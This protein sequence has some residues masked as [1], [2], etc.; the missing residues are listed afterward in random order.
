MN[1]VLYDFFTADHRRIE[2]LLEKATQQPDEIDRE[3]YHQFRIGL[4]KHIKMEE[5]ILFPAA[6]K[7]NGGIDLPLQ[8]RLKKDHGALTALL[9]VS[10]NAGI[11]KILRHILELH[12]EL[13]E[14]EGGMYEACAALTQAETATL[15]SALQH[16]KEVPVHP[17]N[18]DAIA[19]QS[20]K[21]ALQRAGYDFEQLLKE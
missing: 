21:N 15:I 3:L 8:A 14:K 1:T 6:K 19:L 16:T 12:D 9:V 5:R 17:H 18:D 13:E 2:A 20:A 11:I 7:A 4:L 10:P